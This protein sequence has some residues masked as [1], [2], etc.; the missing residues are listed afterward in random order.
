MGPCYAMLCLWTSRN[1]GATSRK[2]KI[3]FHYIEQLYAF[4]WG[5]NRHNSYEAI[6]PCHLAFHGGD[7]HTKRTS[8]NR[9]GSRHKG[10]RYTGC[11]TVQDHGCLLV[12]LFKNEIL[13]CL[14]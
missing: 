8:S 6:D 3:E 12:V 14:V 2:L 13:S 1:H 4:E 7:R 10:I 5:D 9:I 11:H